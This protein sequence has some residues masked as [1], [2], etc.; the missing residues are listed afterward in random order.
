LI[1]ERN[2]KNVAGN[3]KHQETHSPGA[4]QAPFWKDAFR[5]QC[6]GVGPALA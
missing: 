2:I 1:V 5:W 4:V 6:Y 3:K